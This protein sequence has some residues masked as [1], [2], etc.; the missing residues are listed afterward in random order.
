MTEVKAFLIGNPLQ[1]LNIL[2]E[3]KDYF[4]L[5]KY[6]GGIGLILKATAVSL[7]YIP[8]QIDLSILRQGQFRQRIF[9]VPGVEDSDFP[10]LK[11]NKG[12]GVK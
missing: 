11:I 5:S 2:P 7:V 6:E 8:V 3:A 12:G 1:L 9:L 10:S 4:L